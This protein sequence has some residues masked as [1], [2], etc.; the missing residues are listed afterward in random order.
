MDFNF[1]SACSS[2]Y[3]T[4]LSSPQSFGNFFFSA[5]TSP[6]RVSSSSSINSSNRVFNVDQINRKEEDHEDFEFNF[7]GQ[8][9]R[10]SLSADE[11]FDGGKIRPLKILTSFD[12]IPILSSSTSKTEN[13]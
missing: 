3:M 10:T 4:A 6:S 11:L 2:P 12:L 13:T 7:G 8:L 1:D 5:P 9:E